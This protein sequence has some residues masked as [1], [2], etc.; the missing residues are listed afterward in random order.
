MFV[1]LISVNVRFGNPLIEIVRVAEP[2]D[3]NHRASANA[4][5]IENAFDFVHF[6][7]LYLLEFFGVE[8]ALDLLALP[9][10]DLVGD[11]R[12]AQRALNVED[13]A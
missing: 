13:F 1:V 8:T 6:W 5:P 11:G 10:A 7:L 9:V 12:C 2:L 4:F 3:E